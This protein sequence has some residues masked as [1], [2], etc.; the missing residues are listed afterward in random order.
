MA[1]RR[2]FLATA[3]CTAAGLALEA[4]GIQALGAQA[5]VRRV[6][7]AGPPAAVLTYV[8]APDALIGWP[9]ALR[10]AA[11]AMI[12]KPA[13]D[14]PV[15]GRL[16]GRSGT[17]SLEALMAA[18]PDLVLDV[19][20]TDATYE[21]F[22]ERVRQQTG[23][24]Y[25]LIGGRLADSPAVLRRA[26]ALIGVE[27]RA[28]A[29]AA[30]ASRLIDL[31]SRRRPA[32]AGVRAYLA[33]GAAGLETGLLGSINTEVLE[34]VGAENVAGDGG[35]RGITTLSLEQVLAWNP[36]VIVTQEPGFAPRA[37]ADPV[38]RRVSAVRNG[39]VITV[40]ELPFGWLD[41]PPG[42]NRLIGADW[43]SMRLSGDTDRA[44]IHGSVRE[45]YT[46]F[47]QIRLSDAAL[48]RLLDGAA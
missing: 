40:P 35:G 26:G 37:S 33:R 6:F 20:T 3:G 5:R 14:L 4:S 21:S 32:L 22:A 43:L 16:A 34:F 2:E 11:A 19:G 42:V 18:R 28:E 9:S 31:V 47:Y 13:A 7:A 38:W 36:D 41:G 45:F 23:L 39:R 24:R 25:E 1:S 30:D 29:L 46:R 44:R 12:G 27:A 10:P 15:V 48:S 17:V 8:L